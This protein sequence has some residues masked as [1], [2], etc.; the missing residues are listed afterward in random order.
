MET[1]LQVMSEPKDPRLAAP[2]RGVTLC[3]SSC[4]AGAELAK[5]AQTVL[6]EFPSMTAML[7]GSQD[8]GNVSDDPSLIDTRW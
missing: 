7:G 2:L 6:P 8:H 4:S 1:N 5:A 3:F